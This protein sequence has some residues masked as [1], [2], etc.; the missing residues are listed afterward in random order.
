MNF[1]IYFGVSSTPKLPKF[2][3][4]LAFNTKLSNGFLMIY[5]HKDLLH[6]PHPLF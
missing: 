3:T 4:F 6:M 5:T 2:V 1:L